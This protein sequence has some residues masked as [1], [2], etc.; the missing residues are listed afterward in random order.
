MATQAVLD[1]ISSRNLPYNFKHVLSNR[2]AG[3]AKI[4]GSI[5]ACLAFGILNQNTK[6]DLVSCSSERVVEDFKRFIKTSLN[7]LE[8]SIFPGIFENTIF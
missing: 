7:S 2:V 3:E 4:V 5:F 1:E 8:S 6:L